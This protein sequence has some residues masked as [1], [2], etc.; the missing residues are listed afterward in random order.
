MKIDQKVKTRYDRTR[1]I[2]GER[3]M[4]TTPLDEIL[5]IKD[6]LPKKQRLLC[7]YLALNYEQIGVMTVAELAEKAG[8]G[9]TTVMRLVQTLGYQ[10][11]T[12]FKRELVQL[13]LVRNTSS[14][15]GLKQSFVSDKQT[16]SSDTLRGV[17]ADS[18]RVLENLCTPANVE[19]FEKAIQ[20][21]LRSESIYTIG[22]R[23]S[24]ALALYFEYG[25]GSFYPHVR[26][27]SWEGEF[28]YDRISLNMKPTD[29]LLVFSVWPCTKK[30]IQV[31][32]ISHR[33]GVP[34]VLVTNT[35]LNPLA[36]VAD[37]VLDTNSVNHSSGDVSLFAVVEAMVAELGR[38]MAPES[39]QNIER[40][41][42]VLSENDLILWEN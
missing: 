28:V 39:T 7:N 42:R 19:Q 34:L 36:K 40:V 27:L 31:G 12:A 11:F 8:V 4:K 21:M 25:V 26:Q 18:L 13:A 24:V 6:V 10:S 17:T 23:S 5:K 14:Y 20:L 37:V 33:L 30:T 1:R 16:E 3:P 32:E 41:E 15:R 9:T 29:V 2:Q 38:R 22:L 35:S